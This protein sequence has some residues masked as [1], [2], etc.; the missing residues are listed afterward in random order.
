[1]SRGQTP[2]HAL[3][4][5]L[6][7]GLQ[8][9]RALEPVALAEPFE[10]GLE[11]LLVRHRGG[12]PAVAADVACGPYEGQKMGDLALFQGQLHRH[13]YRAALDLGPAEDLVG[14]D[15][16]DREVAPGPVLVSRRK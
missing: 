8:L 6:D 12:D 13:M 5:T 3:I 2:R 16:E 7:R 4:V 1:M 11:R 15:L 9:G 14:A 10:C